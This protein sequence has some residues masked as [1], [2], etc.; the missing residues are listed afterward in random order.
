MDSAECACTWIRVTWLV[1]TMQT[2]LCDVP[3]PNVKLSATFIGNT[4]A[5]QEVR[6]QELAPVLIPAAVQALSLIHI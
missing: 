2:S 1:L 6:L 5:I 4:T 3:P